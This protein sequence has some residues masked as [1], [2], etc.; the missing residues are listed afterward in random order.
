MCNEV[1]ENAHIERV[2]GTIKNQYLRHW[3]ITNFEDLKKRLKN[4]INAYNHSKPHSSLNKLSPDS[5]E[6]YVKEL[7]LAE[8]PKLSI[9]T[10][11]ETKNINPNQC[12]IQF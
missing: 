2:N 10:S 12:I 8:R 5:F 7:K 9:W 4:A 3:K 11:N 1:Y 6:Q